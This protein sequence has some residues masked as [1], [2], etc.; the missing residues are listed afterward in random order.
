MDLKRAASIYLDLNVVITLGQI[1]GLHS[2]G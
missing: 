2:K 1:K